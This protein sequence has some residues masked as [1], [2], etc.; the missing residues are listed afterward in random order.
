MLDEESNNIFILMNNY[1]LNNVHSKSYCYK[2]I[3]NLSCRTRVSEDAPR[4]Y[5]VMKVSATDHDKSYSNHNIDYRI[6]DGNIRDVFAITGTTGEIILM[7]SLDREQ[8]ASYTLKVQKIFIEN[9]NLFIYVQ[10]ESRIINFP[11]QLYKI[12]T[13]ILLLF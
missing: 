8:E 13:F 2:Y 11:F 6:T 7:K 10:H 9:T 3:I 5:T 4:G 1:N 12:K